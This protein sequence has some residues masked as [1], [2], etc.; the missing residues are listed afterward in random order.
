[1]AIDTLIFD[2]GGVPGRMHA[3][4]HANAYGL[5]GYGSLTLSFDNAVV[6]AVPEPGSGALLV[7]G[8][9]LWLPLRPVRARWLM[10]YA[11]LLLLILEL[12]GVTDLTVPFVYFQF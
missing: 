7:A 12:F 10:P 4:L 5:N 3:G 11:L 2:L 6:R 8:F 1:M 9:G